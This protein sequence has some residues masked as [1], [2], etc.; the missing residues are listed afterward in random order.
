MCIPSSY[1]EPDICSG[2][3][4]FSIS[5]L[6]AI[7]STPGLRALFVTTRSRLSM[8]ISWAEDGLYLPLLVLLRLYSRWMVEADL[9]F[10]ISFP[11]SIAASDSILFISFAMA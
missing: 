10:G 11:D 3:H 9:F 5:N 4:L 7:R 8:A 1:R 6:R 2:D